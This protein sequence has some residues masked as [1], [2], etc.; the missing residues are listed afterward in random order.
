MIRKFLTAAAL[1]LAV[2]AP[3]VAEPLARDVFSAIPGPTGGA[4]VAIGNYS[5]GC[6]A[7]A[8]QMPESG[9]TWQLMR[10]SRNRVWG[11]P[12][13]WIFWSASRRPPVSLAGAGFIS[14]ISASRAAAR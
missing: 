2:A 4:P 1:T 5:N 14:A 7:G 6:V 3:A 13:W 8:V 9:P 12:S 10:L 11:I